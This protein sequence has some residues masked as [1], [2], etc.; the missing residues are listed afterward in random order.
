MN[1]CEHLWYLV[2]YNVR[3][4]LSQIKLAGATDSG[5]V[6]LSSF[7]VALLATPL[8]IL[9]PWCCRLF[10]A[11]YY[12]AFERSRSREAKLAL[13]S[14]PVFVIIFSNT[15]RFIEFALVKISLQYT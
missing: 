2:D 6:P 5:V 11:P 7:V 12:H 4:S 3:P 10:P 8:R 14:I 15:S 13:L 1:G 9:E